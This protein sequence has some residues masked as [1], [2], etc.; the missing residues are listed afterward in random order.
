MLIN[1][2]VSTGSVPHP[3]NRTTNPYSGGAGRNVMGHKADGLGCGTFHHADDGDGFGDGCPEYG[4]GSG[5]GNTSSWR[6][7]C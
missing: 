1:E 6:N 5:N 3:R 2:L 4:N 7:L